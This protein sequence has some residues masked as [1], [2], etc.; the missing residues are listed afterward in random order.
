[1]ARVRW[2]TDLG[3][4]KRGAT[5]AALVRANLLRLLTSPHYSLGDAVGAVRGMR[6]TQERLLADL[7]GLDLFASAPRIPVPVALFQGRHDAAAPPE[8][9]RRYHDGLDAPRGKALVWFEQSA[10]LPHVEEPERFRRSLLEWTAGAR[11]GGDARL[12]D[13]A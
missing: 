5:F 2:V 10:H 11:Q 6:L 4:V 8:L 9:T 12:T 13:G 1:M 3:G 7:Q